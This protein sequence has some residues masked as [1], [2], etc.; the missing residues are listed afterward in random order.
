MRTRLLVSSLLLVSGVAAFA[1]CA[2]KKP[3]PP[4]E[5]TIT[6]T[7][8]DAGADEDADAEPPP[9]QSLYDRLGGKEAI[10]KV[11]DTFVKNVSADNKVKKRFK[12]LKGDKLEK[13][14]EALVNQLCQ[15]TGGDCTYEG[16]S[17][18]EVHKGLKIKE[19][20]WNA[21]VMDLKAALE[22]NEVG[23]TEQSDLIAILAP[24]K[25]DIVAPP[26]GKK[27]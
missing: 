6:E 3:P 2:A 20:E 27:K 14:K 23:E 16:K 21:V 11:V 9:P 25:D 24:M 13:F 15:A 22:E 18:K 4:M 1:A 7:V 19:A 17:M 12:K 8:T 5:P 26:K 10:A